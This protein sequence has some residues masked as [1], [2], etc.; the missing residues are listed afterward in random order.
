MA[1]NGVQK[2]FEARQIQAPDAIVLPHGSMAYMSLAKPERRIY[3]LCGQLAEKLE[4]DP[5]REL[6]VN[7][8]GNN[9]QVFEHRNMN[10]SP[11]SSPPM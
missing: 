10:V 9:L 11:S 8:F 5:K 6:A 3:A 7:V 4:L 1:L 2:L